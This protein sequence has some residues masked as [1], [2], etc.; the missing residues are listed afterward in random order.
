MKLPGVSLPL[1]PHV[2]SHRVG[3]FNT[4]NPTKSL[5]WSPTPTGKAAWVASQHRETRA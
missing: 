1:G 5:L 4:L 2:E 3:E